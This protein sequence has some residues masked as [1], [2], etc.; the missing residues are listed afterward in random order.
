[1]PLAL[2][3]ALPVA[4]PL[5]LALP[6]A[7]TPGSRVLSRPASASAPFPDPKLQRPSL[8]SNYSRNTCCSTLHDPGQAGRASAADGYVPRCCSQAA[9]APVMPQ[10]A[11]MG[12]G[13]LGDSTSITGSGSGRQGAQGRVPTSAA[14][15]RSSVRLDGAASEWE[16]GSTVDQSTQ[17]TYSQQPRLTCRCSVQR[18]RRCRSPL[19]PS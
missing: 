10:T 17:Y 11:M 2:A 5:R 14:P 15:R 3:P 1:M 7:S 4:V 18:Q 8:P 9:T 13:R 6:V 19:R 16:V 12:T